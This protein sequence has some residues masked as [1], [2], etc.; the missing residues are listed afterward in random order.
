MIFIAYNHESIIIS[1]VSTKSK[2]SANAY[3][4][5]RGII[6][7][8]SKEFNPNDPRENEEQGYVTPLLITKEVDV[9]LVGYA[10]PRK[11]IKVEK[12]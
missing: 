12:C 11:I 3:W 7:H 10:Y 4:Q 5:G 9:R 2:S 8:F 6:P 1:I